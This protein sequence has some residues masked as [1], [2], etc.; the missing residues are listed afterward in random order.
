M[1]GKAR[2][3]SIISLFIILHLFFSFH[4]LNRPGKSLTPPMDGYVLPSKITKILS[5]EFGGLVADFM[6]LKFKTMVGANIETVDQF[7]DTQW[8][9]LIKGL[10][11]ITDLDP[12]FWEA[13]YFSETFLTWSAKRYNAANAL[14]FK[15]KKYLPDEYKIP[16]YIGFN[17]FYFMKD[18]VKGAQYMMEAS[19]LPESPPYLVTFA[20][21]LSSQAM[22]M[23]VGILFLKDM[24]NQTQD[25]KIRKHYQKRLMALEM[26]ELLHNAKILYEKKYQKALSSLDQLVISGIM[27]ELPRDPY[28]GEFVLLDNGSVY[29]TSNLVQQKSNQ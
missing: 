12:Y 13:Y 4:I 29:T 15:A 19:K 25:E 22:Q 28:G 23:R 18:N 3:F 7:T 17:Y 6:L 10:D 2:V 26:L 1:K 11:T 16:F 24:I 8:D 21:R 14:L 9:Y 27:N 20:A 5:L